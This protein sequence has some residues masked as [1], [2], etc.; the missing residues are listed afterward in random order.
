MFGQ[1]DS[2]V[3]SKYKGSKMEWD[4]DE[5]E[6][7][8]ETEPTPLIHKRQPVSFARTTGFKMRN[9]FA[10]L[11]LDDDDNGDDNDSDDRLDTSTVFTVPGVVGVDA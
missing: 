7:P 8:L 10:T 11:R 4:V 5:C 6:Q 2:D 3:P 1:T 9:R